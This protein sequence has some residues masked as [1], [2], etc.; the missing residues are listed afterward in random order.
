MLQQKKN[1]KNLESNAK[2]MNTSFVC[3]LSLFC[4]IKDLVYCMWF[5]TGQ[6]S[7]TDY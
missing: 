5:I 1:L 2:L 6:C 4:I 7:T 3:E